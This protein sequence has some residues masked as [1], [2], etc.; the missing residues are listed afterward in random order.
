MSEFLTKL[1]RELIDTVEAR[2]LAYQGGCLDYARNNARCTQ[3]RKTTHGH[4]WPTSRRVQDSP[5]KS[6]SQ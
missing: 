3:V 6:Q 2:K 4:G 5:W 1:K